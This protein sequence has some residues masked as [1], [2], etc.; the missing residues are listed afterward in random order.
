M[1]NQPQL[2][3]I[4]PDKE[5][6]KPTAQKILALLEKGWV[7]PLMAQEFVHTTEFRARVSE[8]RRDG[9]PLESEWRTNLEG[10]RFKAWRMRT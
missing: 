2:P 9:W 4:H 7:T 8:I 5:R 10:K 3:G 1:T 6:L